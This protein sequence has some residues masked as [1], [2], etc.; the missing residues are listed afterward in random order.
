MKLPLGFVRMTELAA[1][2]RAEPQ[3]FD[4]R[5]WHAV[6]GGEKNEGYPYP[7]NTGFGRKTKWPCGTTHCIGGMAQIKFCPEAQSLSEI[8][9]ELDLAPEFPYKYMFFVEEW[10]EEL[11]AAYRRGITHQEKAES[12][13]HVIEYYRDLRW[14]EIARIIQSRSEEQHA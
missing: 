2:V 3:K 6:P 11:S 8:L 4:M 10:P 12:A 9:Q 14:P 1:S 5:Y 13:A 7:L